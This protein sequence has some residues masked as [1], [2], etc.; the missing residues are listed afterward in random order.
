MRKE[1]R[2]GDHD[3]GPTFVSVTLSV[4]QPHAAE[5]HAA[6][7]S[8]TLRLRSARKYVAHIGSPVTG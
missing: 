3:P 2:T 8:Q 1:V 7:P 4:T 6:A 5:P